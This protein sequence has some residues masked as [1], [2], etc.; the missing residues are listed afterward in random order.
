MRFS[1]FPGNFTHKLMIERPNSFLQ[2]LIRTFVFFSREAIS[3]LR[4]GTTGAGLNSGPGHWIFD[5][6]ISYAEVISKG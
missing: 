1:D 4:H 2:C 6:F 5:I 3:P